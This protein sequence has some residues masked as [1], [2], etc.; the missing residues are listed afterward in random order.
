MR[1]IDRVRNEDHGF[2]LSNIMNIIHRFRERDRVSG[3]MDWIVEILVG[4][5]GKLHCVCG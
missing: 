5:K 2:H 4:F 1:L 3:E